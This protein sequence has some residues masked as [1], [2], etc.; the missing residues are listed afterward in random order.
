MKNRQL[1]ILLILFSFYIATQTNLV[2]GVSPGVSSGDE[3]TYEVKVFYNSANQSATI[4]QYQLDI[5]KTD[6]FKVEITGVDGNDVSF[7][8]I[9]RF[10]NGTENKNQGSVDIST[11]FAG[12]DFWAIIGSNMNAGNKLHPTGPDRVFINDTIIRNYE[13]GGNRETNLVEITYTYYN[14]DDP[15]LFYNEYSKTY[16]DK[17][18]GMLVELEERVVFPDPLTTE[19]LTWKLIETNSFVDSEFP[20]TMILL[21]IIVLSIIGII[22]YKII[23]KKKSK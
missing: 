11:G 20:I 19:K 18:T 12:G 16:F 4:S 13:P 7:N 2:H 1:A 3:F 17:Q 22:S 21:L 5:N 6:Y 8:S 9:W 15:S 23:M 14:E 10:I